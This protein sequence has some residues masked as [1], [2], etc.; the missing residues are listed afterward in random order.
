[1]LINL[2]QE[3]VLFLLLSCGNSRKYIKYFRYK[4]GVVILIIFPI[5]KWR[6]IFIPDSTITSALLKTPR[7]TL[8]RLPQRDT[9]DLKRLG[10]L[11]YLLSS[12][13]MLSPRQGICFSIS[14]Q[15]RSFVPPPTSNPA[16]H[17][18]FLNSHTSPWLIRENSS[19]LPLPILPLTHQHALFMGVFKSHIGLAWIVRCLKWAMLSISLQRIAP[20]LGPQPQRFYVCVPGCKSEC[21]LSRVDRAFIYSTLKA[22]RWLAV[23]AITSLHRSVSHHL[24]CS[25]FHISARNVSMRNRHPCLWPFDRQTVGNRTSEDRRRQ[26][27]RRNK[28]EWCPRRV[29]AMLPHWESCGVELNDH[30]WMNSGRLKLCCG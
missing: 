22:C 19:A 30:A 15:S 21:T 28:S 18:V 26:R 4:C 11:E 17:F 16:S 7:L 12:A 20:L 1:M 29:N 5:P 14:Q 13:T 2:A 23:N 8:A 6:N 24:P 10:T 27:G 25:L 3:I 9:S